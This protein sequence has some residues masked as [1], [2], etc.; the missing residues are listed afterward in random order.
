MRLHS[1]TPVVGILL[2][3]GC[4][5]ALFGI[6]VFIVLAAH[7]LDVHSPPFGLVHMAWL[8]IACTTLVLSAL[9]FIL[10]ALFPRS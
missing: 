4:A 3:I 8:L 10:S 9:A 5:P 6:V 1:R 2:R 7:S